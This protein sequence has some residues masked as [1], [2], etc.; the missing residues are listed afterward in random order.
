MH[1]TLQPEPC[2]TTSCF[3]TVMN[4]TAGLWTRMQCSRIS[5]SNNWNRCHRSMAMMAGAQHVAVC[6]LLM[7][8]A[9]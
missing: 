8:S 3:A 6:A 7:M 4:A 9:Q 2:V 5:S 1:T